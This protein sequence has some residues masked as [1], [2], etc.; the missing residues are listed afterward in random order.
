[1]SAGNSLRGDRSQR[2]GRRSGWAFVLRALMATEGCEQGRDSHLL[3]KVFKGF[4]GNTKGSGK[5]RG[6]SPYNRLLESCDRAGT[7]LMAVEGAH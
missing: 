7:V 3:L 2:K 5:E 4:L 1:M 6:G